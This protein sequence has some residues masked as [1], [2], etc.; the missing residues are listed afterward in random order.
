MPASAD[1]RS[2]RR[3]VDAVFLR[4]H[5]LSERH[6]A[7]R[8]RALH[9]GEIDALPVMT[10]LYGADRNSIYLSPAPLYHA[11]PLGFS[12]ACLRNGIQVVVMEHFEA[13]RAL[14][15][16]RAVPHHAQPVGADDVRADAEAAGSDVQNEIRR[17]E[18]EVARY[19]RRRRARF[20]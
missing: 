17:V 2:D 13:E 4:Y 20:R 1:R 9:F 18:S 19:T 11:A 12:M 7:S 8:C 3:S 5:R 6:Q 14:R 15:I 16:H 10:T